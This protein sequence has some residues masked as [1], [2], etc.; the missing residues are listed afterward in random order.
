[1]HPPVLWVFQGTPLELWDGELH[2]VAGQLSPLE[3]AAMGRSSV[4]CQSERLPEFS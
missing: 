1:M 3:T 2:T 4:P